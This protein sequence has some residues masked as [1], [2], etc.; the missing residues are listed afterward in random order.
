VNVRGEIVDPLG[1][2]VSK[3]AVTIND[4]TSAERSTKSNREGAF[5]INNLAPRKYTVRV[6]DDFL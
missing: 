5:T 3:P 4:S 2:L 1:A 6:V